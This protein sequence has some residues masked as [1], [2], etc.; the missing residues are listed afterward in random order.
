M[1]NPTH[2]HKKLSLRE[3][4]NKIICS[5]RSNVFLVLV[6]VG[7]IVNY[8]T[9]NV[10]LIFVMNFLAIIPSAK[11][12]KFAAIEFSHHFGETLGSLLYISFYNLVELIVTIIALVNGQIR[13][14]Q[15][16]ILGSIFSHLLLVLG[17]CFLVAGVEF[18]FKKNEL[19]QA[20]NSTAAQMSSSVMTLACISLVI[21]AAFSLLIN[22]NYNAS[23]ASNNNVADPKILYISYGTSMVLLIIYAL[24]LCFK[25]KTHK[26]ML[27]EY[28]IAI[29][30]VK[31]ETGEKMSVDG[32]TIESEENGEH[33]GEHEHNG[34]YNGEHMDEKRKIDHPIS[35]VAAL[36]LLIIMTVI[37]G[38]S[39][40][41]LVKSIE[42]IVESHEI[43]KTFIG[44]ILFPMVG[45][46]AKYVASLR[47]ARRGEMNAVIIIS[48]GSATQTALFI[49]PILV[50]LGWIINQPMSLAFLP[51]ETI[52]L[53]IAVV[54]KNYLVQ[55]HGKSNWLEGALLIATYLIIAVAFFFYPEH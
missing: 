31:E 28:E 41:F 18:Y 48:V 26:S 33:N 1:S 4:L 55:V 25:L 51:F 23:N 27:E 5:S 11:M 14:V 54:L 39:A 47:T 29:K 7:Y 37:I 22:G 3:T 34:E 17:L 30:E 9:T 10:I 42:G 36:T 21:P 20:F 46:G 8:L 24:F 35:I 6:P 50:L 32:Q 44:I 19:E 15:A 38:F 43:S 52:C 12:L 2:E 16:A 13:V 40:E 53:F 45:H 49:T